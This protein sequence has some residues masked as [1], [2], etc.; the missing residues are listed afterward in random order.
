MIPTAMGSP[1]RLLISIGSNKSGAFFAFPISVIT[2]PGIVSLL[3][4]G[5]EIYYFS[6]HRRGEVGYP[7]V[8]VPS[9]SW[10]F[11]RVGNQDFSALGQALQ[12]GSLSDAQNAFSTLQQDLQ[13]FGL[14]ANAVSSSS[15]AA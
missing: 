2:E 1:V 14:S 7:R 5:V 12:S 11:E 3:N 13:K 6:S 8:S 4:R 10:R 9:L 15:A